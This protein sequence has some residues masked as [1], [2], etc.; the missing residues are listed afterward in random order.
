MN[1]KGVKLK[2]DSYSGPLGKVKGFEFSAGKIINEGDE[3]E[4]EVMGPTP[5][6]HIPTLRPWFFKLM[7]R[8]KPYYMPNSNS[9]RIDG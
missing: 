4:W 2:I 8:Y 1:E 7:E 6:P 9:L 3:S 5:K